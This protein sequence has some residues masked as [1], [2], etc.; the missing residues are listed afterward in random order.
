MRAALG[1]P[2]HGSLALLAG[3]Q[4][5]F[6]FAYGGLMAVIIGASGGSLGFSLAV[7]T[8]ITSA[9]FTY[10]DAV[11]PFVDA[12]L[13]AKS[14]SALLPYTHYM[15]VQVMQFQMDS[16]VRETLPAL[17]VLALFSAILLPLGMWMLREV[18]K[19]TPE[20]GASGETSQPAAGA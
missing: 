14:L 20:T 17:G 11:F 18:M 5:L 12:S 16:T 10:G 1:F 2:V 7:C 6:Y 19:L 3:A 13:F 4:F 8:M 15:R 9:A